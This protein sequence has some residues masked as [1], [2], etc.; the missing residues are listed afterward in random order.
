MEMTPLSYQETFQ[1]IQEL[2]TCADELDG[3]A[4]FKKV[5]SCRR[6]RKTVI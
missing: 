4:C 5:R 2:N 1:L 6:T 3:A